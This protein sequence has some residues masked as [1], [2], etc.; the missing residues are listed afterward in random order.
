[1]ERSVIEGAATANQMCRKGASR[2]NVTTLESAYVE[3][4]NKYLATHT[5]RRGQVCCGW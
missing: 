2:V 1:M 5:L 4:W 3:Y